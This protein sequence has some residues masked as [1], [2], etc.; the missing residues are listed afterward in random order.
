MFY[1]S[2][3][4][5]YQPPEDEKD[6][7]LAKVKTDMGKITQQANDLEQQA[8]ATFK[9][10]KLSSSQFDA[11]N[12][13]NKDNKKEL[14]SKF[15]KLNNNSD[16]IKNMVS[17]IDD[18]YNYLLNKCKLKTYIPPYAVYIYIYNVNVCF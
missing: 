4:S 17:E 18:A 5:Q 9:K 15:E 14:N 6:T 3:K 11:I 12:K 13:V 8:N 16:S 7:G 2:A 10:F 1:F